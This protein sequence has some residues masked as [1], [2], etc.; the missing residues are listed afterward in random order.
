MI[1][2]STGHLDE[3]AI[4]PACFFEFFSE[5]H[6]LRGGRNSKDARDEDA[7]RSRLH[8][9]GVGRGL[10]GISLRADVMQM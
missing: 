6:R 4:M 10:G 1:Q 8:R 7:R 9:L 2:P 5:L 3:V